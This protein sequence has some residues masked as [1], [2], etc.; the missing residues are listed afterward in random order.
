MRRALADSTFLRVY[1][2]LAAT[3]VLALGVAMVGMTL[4]DKVRIEHYREQL[5]EAPMHLL[6]T[7]I[8]SMPR[9][10]RREWMAEKS[11]A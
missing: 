4:I 6:A 1:V 3:L 7:M 2:M 8:D 11:E 9:G 10:D 5:A